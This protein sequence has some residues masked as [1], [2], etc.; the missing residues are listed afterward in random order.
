MTV[1]TY[2]E[3]E[4]ENLRLVTASL[5]EGDQHRRILRA[6]GLAEGPLPAVD[7]ETLARYYAYLSQNLSF[8]FEATYPEPTNRREVQLYTCTVRELVDPSQDA[9][10]EFDGIFCK[11]DKGGFEVNLPLIEL[12]VPQQSPNFQMIE[13]YWYWFW[14]WR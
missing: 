1:V 2:F 10:T 7:D 14:N 8:P 5:P 9:Y 12:E 4:G 3:A 11:A 13:D 6:L